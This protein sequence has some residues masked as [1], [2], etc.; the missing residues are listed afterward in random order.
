[1]TAAKLRQ[2]KQ[3]ELKKCKNKK[4]RFID[5]NRLSCSDLRRSTCNRLTFSCKKLYFA[6]KTGHN[7]SQT[8]KLFYEG[9]LW[10]V[11]EEKNSGDD[12]KIEALLDALKNIKTLGTVSRSSAASE[13]DRYGFTDSQTLTVKAEKSGKTIR[14]LKIGKNSETNLSSYVKLDEKPETL[15]ADRNLRSI[16]EVKAEDLE[17]KIEQPQAEQPQAEEQTSAN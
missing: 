2:R 16:F 8:V 1:M 4:N 7:S 12:Q 13:L 6:G 10:Y 17:Q 3:N 5:S 14:T 11:G 9:G 15:L